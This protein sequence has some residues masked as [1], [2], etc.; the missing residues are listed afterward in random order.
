MCEC[1]CS[2]TDMPLGPPGP[3]GAT[4]ATG[5]TGATG[6]NG[7]GATGP[8]GTTGSTGATGPTGGTGNA[9]A[10][11]TTGG[12]GNAGATG[13]TGGTGSAGP[14]GATG[15]TGAAGATGP[16]GA[17]GAAGASVGLI[18]ATVGVS[19]AQILALFTTPQ[20]FLAAPGA[21]RSYR[22][23]S[24]D[25]SMDYQSI[26][27]ANNQI[28][29]LIGAVSGRVYASLNAAMLAETADNTYGMEMKDLAASQKIPLNEA[30]LIKHRTNDPINGNSAINFS[31]LYK[32]L[33]I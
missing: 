10:T 22:F 15:P 27:Y 26:P 11:G 17:T 25:A 16:T 1:G 3:T 12:T 23:V 20:T 6:A 4:G 19:P 18:T 5:P 32:L 31:A 7:T 21:N 13:P 8:T 33:S 24:A 28:I 29:D 30:I 9:G 2:S 14:T